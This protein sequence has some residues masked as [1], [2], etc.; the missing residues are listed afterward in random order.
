M[1]FI[2][3]EEQMPI[4]LFGIILLTLALNGC[5][6]GP[7]KSTTPPPAYHI[8]DQAMQTSSVDWEDGITPPAK[9][10]TL[11]SAVNLSPKQ[12]QRALKSAGFYAEAVDGKIGPKTKDAII[13]FQKANNLRADGIVGKKT[14]VVLNKYLNQ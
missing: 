1:V 5:A 6:T 14:S 10:A 2:Y 11:S 3:K 9:A 7:A 4:K 13:R 8:P 12:I